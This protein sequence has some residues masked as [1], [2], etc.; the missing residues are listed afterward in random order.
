MYLEVEFKAGGSECGHYQGLQA[1]SQVTVLKDQGQGAL[2]D[3]A[4]RGAGDGAAH[5]LTDFGSTFF[6]Y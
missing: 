4:A 6:T 3:D 2:V 5:S 1:S